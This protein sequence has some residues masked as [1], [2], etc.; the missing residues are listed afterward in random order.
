[1]PCSKYQR[2]QGVSLEKN[3]RAKNRTP[4]EIKLRACYSNQRWRARSRKDAKGVA[5]EW[6]LSYEQWLEVWGDDLPF[7][8]NKRDD[9]V[10][11]RYGDIGHYEVGNVRIITAHE[12]HLERV[13]RMNADGSFKANGLKRRLLNAAAKART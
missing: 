7:R 4:A 5:I 12:N 11:A 6:K 13:A 10:M 8:G 3:M 1:M 2:K 9:K